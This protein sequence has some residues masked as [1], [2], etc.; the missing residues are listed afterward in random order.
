MARG[1][2]VWRLKGQTI[3]MIWS[4]FF[5]IIAIKMDA[6]NKSFL[7]VQTDNK[8][9]KKIT[10]KN[11]DGLFFFAVF[12]PRGVSSFSLQRDEVTPITG[13]RNNPTPQMLPTPG[14]P[15]ECF[16]NKLFYS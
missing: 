16:I 5:K 2:S 9:R 14:N 11:K 8:K 3:L 6:T 7:L 4:F 15:V 13:E 1:E 10:E 12:R